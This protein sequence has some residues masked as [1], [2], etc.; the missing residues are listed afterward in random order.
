MIAP[1]CIA[2][3][4]LLVSRLLQHKLLLQRASSNLEQKGAK[5]CILVADKKELLLLDP[6]KAAIRKESFAHQSHKIDRG[7]VVL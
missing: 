1:V 7:V 5:E 2:F 3:V 4:G 6:S